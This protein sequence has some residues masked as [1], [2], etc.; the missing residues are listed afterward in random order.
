MK[1][2]ILLS[3]GLDSLVSLAVAKEKYDIGLALT[4]DYGQKAVKQEI[5]A[6]E[7]ICN[8]YKIK[9]KVIK[10]DWLAEITKT[11]LVSE[12]KIPPTSLEDLNS[13]EFVQ[14][15]A[16]SVWVPNRNG[17]LLNIAASFADSFG[18]DYI[19]FGANKEEGTTFPDNTQEFIDRI[20]SA[21]EY[22]TLQK[23]KVFAPLINLNKNDIVKIAVEHNV[24]LELTRSCY[25]AQEKHC[26]VCESCI[27][28]KRALQENNCQELI[29]ELFT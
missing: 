16:A 19:I 29:K 8:Y 10:V 23:P 14:K 13:D 9:H 17:V 22:S 12:K 3:G 11:A 21:F 18:Y 6:S 25:S 2:I 7:K 26:G 1:S 20:N 27:R 28:L 24:P 15:S 4:F 5:L